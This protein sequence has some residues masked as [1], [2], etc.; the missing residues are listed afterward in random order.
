MPWNKAN[1][2]WILL[3]MKLASVSAAMG[4]QGAIRE[5]D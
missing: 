5:S 3:A 2:S 1:Y 4:V